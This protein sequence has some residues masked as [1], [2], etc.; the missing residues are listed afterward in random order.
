MGAARFTSIVRFCQ[1]YGLWSDTL[2]SL[3]SDI[4]PQAPSQRLQDD[5]DEAKTLPLY[6]E[7]AK[8]ELILTPIMRELRRR[9]P[10]LTFFSGF[11][12]AV[13]GEPDL[14]GNPD[15]VLS[16]KPNIV[17]IEAPIFCLVESKNRGIDEG[18]AQCAAD[19]YAARLFNQQMNEPID[20]IYGAVSNGFEWVF[21]KL[22]DQTIYIDRDRHFL[23]EL[24]TLL[25]I[26]DHI[27]RIYVPDADPT[28]S[29]TE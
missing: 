20:T 4:A 24:S 19:M 22:E 14:T 10:R 8:S 28:S 6:T 25:G 21:L 9:H 29:L 27:V 7:K 1:Q 5:L 26:L 11:A 17:E 15:F 18:F 23:S 3:F 13:E 2:R 12:L 16:A